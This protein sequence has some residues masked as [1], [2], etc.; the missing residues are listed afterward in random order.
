MMAGDI[1]RYQD[2]LFEV[3]RYLGPCPVDEDYEPIEDIPDS[4]WPIWASF[5]AISKEDRKEFLVQEDCSHFLVER[6]K[7]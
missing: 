7:E 2:C 5:S 4:F 6:D 1:Y 3:H